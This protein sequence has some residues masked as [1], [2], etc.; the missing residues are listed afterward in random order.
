MC[1]FSIRYPNYQVTEDVGYLLLTVERSG[2]GAGPASVRYALRHFTTSASDVAATAY[3]TDSQT[4]FFDTGVVALS[5]LV[6]VLDD[7]EVEA[8]EV[9][10]MSLERPSAGSVG[11]QSRVN[12]TIVD[13]DGPAASSPNIDPRASS[14]LCYSPS[15]SALNS[16]VTNSSFSTFA[17]GELFSVG[18]QLR[19]TSG[20]RLVVGLGRPTM[21]AVLSLTESWDAGAQVQFE[22]NM[23][24]I[25]DKN[26]GTFNISGVI[27]VPGEYLLHA[28]YAAPGGLRGDYYS[29]AFFRSLS[30]SRVDRV[31]GF[32]WPAGDVLPVAATFVSVRWTGGISAPI[33]GTYFFRLAAN[34]SARLI[35]N[36]KVSFRFD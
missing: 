35:I 31:L 19:L 22:K 8:D 15:V 14:F 34:D 27:S 16:S 25:V 3:Y 21:L 13:D 4:L 26:D 10:Q 18:V 32:S 12:V 29:D 11:P 7:L 36:G 1:H 33:T 5:F 2:G 28:Y 20:S 23:P 30:L 17:A 6:T 9:F 24:N